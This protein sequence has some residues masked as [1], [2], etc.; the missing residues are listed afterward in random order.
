MIY[1]DNLVKIKQNETFYFETKTSY[2]EYKFWSNK[3]VPP[4]TNS[5][6]QFA[7]GPEVVEFS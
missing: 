3:F 6:E 5:L 7:D 2:K 1:I 4:D